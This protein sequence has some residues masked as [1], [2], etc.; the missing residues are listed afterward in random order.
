MRKFWGGQAERLMQHLR[1]H[2]PYD[3]AAKAVPPLVDRLLDAEFWG[4]ENTLLRMWLIDFLTR[5]AQDGVT[6]SDAWTRSKFALEF[7]PTL[8]NADAAK[9]ARQYAGGLAKDVNATTRDSIKQSVANW[10]E[11]PGATIQDLIDAMP[12]NEQR[13]MRVAVTEVTQA[14][15]EGERL[16]TTQLQER[17]P[18]LQI[19][20]VWYTNNDDRVCPI[21]A[22]L[23]G[24]QIGVDSGWSGEGADPEGL[25]GP[26]A[27]PACRCWPG[28]DVITE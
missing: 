8:T 1:G 20:R 3:R 21:C 5:A 2:L 9:W 7:D 11:T 14:Y 19:V 24:M 28:R 23:N 10:I 17:Y 6:I 12:F 27:H 26:P 15:S 18:T 16:Y 13:A 25:V 22:P 4:N